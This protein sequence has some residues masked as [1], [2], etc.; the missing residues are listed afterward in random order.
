[1]LIESNNYKILETESGELYM[2]K[3]HLFVLVVGLM[4]SLNSYAQSG[5]E[6]RS[7]SDGSFFF[8]VGFSNAFFSS[9]P[10]VPFPK[11]EIKK[12]S[13][14][15]IGG[16]YELPMGPGNTFFGLELGYSSGKYFGGSGG[17]DFIPFGVEGAY[18]FPLANILYIGPRLKLGGIG[19]LAP[20]W[21]RVVLT[22]GARLEAEL[23][24]TGFPVGLYVAG[25][26]DVFPTSPEFATLP[27]VEVGL[28]YPR[29]KSKKSGSPDDSKNK[30]PAGQSA[31]GSK[32]DSSSQG[33]AAALVPGA[34]ASATGDPAASTPPT[35]TPTA[36]TPATSTPAAS[37]PAASTPAA[38]TPATPTATTPTATTPVTPPP[39][40]PTITPVTPGTP[41]PAAPSPV[42]MPPS[43]PTPATAAPIITG[44]G[45]GQNR[46]IT[47]EDGRQGILN[48]IYFEPDTAVLIESYR[49]ILESVG[50]QLAAD[51]GL[52]LL[53]RAYAADFGTADGRYIVSVSRARFSRDYFTTQYGVSLNRFN[54]EAF[55]AD[56]SPI[57]AT[58]DWQSHRCVE[59]ILLRD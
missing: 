41:T 56:R 28:R 34:S 7:G 23:R 15:T 51:P 46:S 1:M 43:T 22:A 58:S 3:R 33:T 31:T 54:I 59:L 26:V 50:K 25:G 12:L 13:A 48:S 45:Q 10:V 24:F 37:T 21:N 2:Q 18:V 42:V 29:G 52:K 44:T 8:S 47:L 39:N 27:S 32:D 4:L 17:V 20:N 9:G 16:F 30:M 14:G 11:F 40:T 53:I 38:S 36:S 35:S 6:T 49:P 55:G 5:S 19:L 57:Y